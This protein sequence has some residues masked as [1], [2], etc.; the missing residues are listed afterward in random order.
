MTIG[1]KIR[2]QGRKQYLEAMRVLLTQKPALPIGVVAQ[3]AG[4]T[5]RRVFQIKKELGFAQQAG[6]GTGWQ[7]ACGTTAGLLRDLANALDAP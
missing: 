1:K 7:V 6:E 5:T 3:I 4:V 2:E